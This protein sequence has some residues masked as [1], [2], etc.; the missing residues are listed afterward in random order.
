MSIHLD[1][2][3]RQV[4]ASRPLID[5]IPAGPLVWLRRGQGLV[6]WGQAARAEFTGPERF[7][8]AEAWWREVVAN[9]QVTGDGAVDADPPLCLGSFSFTDGSAAKSVLVVP[10]YLLVERPG[11]RY[12]ISAEPT[13]A[14]GPS[15]ATVSEGEPDFGQPAL[16]VTGWIEKPGHHG[17][18]QW[19]KVIDQALAAISQGQVEKVVLARDVRVGGDK[20]ATAS[21]VIQAL[22]Q[23]YPD[24]WTYSIDGLIGATPELLVRSVGGLV[25]SRVLAGTIRRTGQDQADLARAG[26]LARS[27]K[28]LDEHQY[29]VNSVIEGLRPFVEA[30]SWPDAPSVLH[31]ANVMHLATDVVGDLTG[32]GTN[33][34]AWSVRLAGALHPTAAVCGTPQ[35]AAAQLIEQLEGQDR[36]RYAGPVGWMDRLGQGEWGIALRCG[37]FSPDQRSAQLWA[38]G[39]IVAASLPAE[40]LAETE[41]KLGAMRQALGLD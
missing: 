36:G 3:A 9:C 35:A 27:S 6:G 24:C 39:G 11:R 33:S 2:T 25:T 16:P 14:T 30:L 5:S 19:L 38:G 34:Q 32:R 20:P 4:R 41:A 37:Q 12:L 15:A 1:V 18:D 7:A 31:L 8:Q 29:A 23:S 40:E 13:G 22:C 21:G 17:P 28:D 10:Q 26:A